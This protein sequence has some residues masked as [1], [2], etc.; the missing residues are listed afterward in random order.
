MSYRKTLEQIRIRNKHKKSYTELL[1]KSMS[2]KSH[3][4]H[5]QKSHFIFSAENPFHPTKHSMTHEEAMDFLDVRGYDVEEMQGK[6][7]DHERSILV[8]NPK[9]H[10][11]KHLKQLASDL[12][13]DSSIVSSDGYNHELHFHHGDSAG[14]HIKGQGTNL[15]R[16]EPKDNYST[17]EDGTH[18][19][20]NFSSDEYHNDRDSLVPDKPSQ[21]K[22]SEFSRKTPF[23]AKSENNHPLA[24]NSQDMKLIHYS[25]TQ[26]LNELDSLYQGSRQKDASSKQGTPKNPMNFFYMEGAKPENIVTSGAKSKYVTSVGDK[27]LYDRGTDTDGIGSKIHASLKEEANKRQ[28]NPGVVSNE[29]YNNSL[30]SR[31]NKMGFHGIY[32]SSLDDTMSKVVGLF[33]NVGLDSE[34]QIHPNDFKEA[35]AVDHHKEEAGM[36]IATDFANENGHHD[37]KFLNSLINSI[38]EN[39]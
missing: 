28:T 17:L 18:F 33:G 5:D 37:P 30:H 4:I 36:K 6:Y 35:S 12:G 1:C 15:H 8:K 14:K 32:N 2:K 39:K 16:F 26:G 38:R 25:P 22:K 11:F 27:K 34:H 3:P 29:E 19:T 13:Q 7:G 21:M 31:L 24:G 9:P 10:H 23:L 20:H